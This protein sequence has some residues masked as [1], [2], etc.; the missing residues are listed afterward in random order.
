MDMCV[1]FQNQKKKEKRKK[2]SKVRRK[3]IAPE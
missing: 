3:N 1:L 2:N